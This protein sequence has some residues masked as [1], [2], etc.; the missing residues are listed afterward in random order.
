MTTPDDRPDPGGVTLR[1]D[2]VR[3]LGDR[4]LTAAVDAILDRAVEADRAGHRDYAA[5]LYNAAVQAIR[6]AQKR[7]AAPDEI[8]AVFPDPD[9][10]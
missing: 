5:Q 4:L 2:E 8:G 9:K 1:R 10:A 7:H 3:L 6:A